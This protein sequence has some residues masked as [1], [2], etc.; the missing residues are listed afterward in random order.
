M[1]L[2]SVAADYP[3]FTVKAVQVKYQCQRA[4]VRLDLN[5]T[6]GAG[7]SPALQLGRD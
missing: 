3:K 7:L 6:L 4:P 5:T 2:Q 1:L